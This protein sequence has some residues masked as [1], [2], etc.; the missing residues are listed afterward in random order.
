MR[1]IIRYALVGTGAVA[2]A[3]VRALRQ[4]P[5]ARLDIVLSRDPARAR[6]FAGQ[7]G[8]RRAEAFHESVFKTLDVDA[9]V[10][11]TE[12]GW[13]ARAGIAAARAGKH[14]M[15]EKP[16][17]ANIEAAQQLIDACQASGVSL[18]VT[19]TMPALH[20]QGIKA[21]AVP[22]K[23]RIVFFQQGPYVYELT[24]SADARDYERYRPAFE[25][26]L[27]S[28]RLKESAASP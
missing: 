14:V 12:P 16:I 27:S 2:P 26:L 17:E 23:E 15:V 8:V 5:N 13:H 25:H 11:A 1:A 24:Y 4:I 10:V 19:S 9:V 18:T 20:H 28:L 21:E 7:H 3:H 22:L 6:A